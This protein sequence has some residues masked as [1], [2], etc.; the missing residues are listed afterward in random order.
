MREAIEQLL[1]VVGATEVLQVAMEGCLIGAEG[2]WA[3]GNQKGRM[4]R[5]TNCAVNQK[6]VS[7]FR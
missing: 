2:G 4:L 5:R 6:A 7:N 3:E 1:L